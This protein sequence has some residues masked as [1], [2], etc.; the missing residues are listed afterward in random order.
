MSDLTRHPSLLTYPAPELPLRGTPSSLWERLNLVTQFTIVATVVIG[1]IMAVLGSWISSRIENSVIRYTASSAAL[2]MDRFV[3]PYLQDLAHRD[4]LSAQ[5]KAALSELLKTKA[6]NRHVIKIKIWRPD[7]TI[8]FSNIEKLIGTKPP[9]SDSLAKALTGV[10]APEFDRLS[11]VENSAE[12]VLQKPLLEIYAPVRETNGDRIIAVAE[13]YQ[14]AEDLADELFW[15]RLEGILMVGGFSLLMLGALIGIVG[16]GSQTIVTQQHALNQRI[17]E[18][19]NSLTQN[20]ELRSRLADANRRASESNERFLRRVSAELHDGPVQLIGLSLLRLDEI[21][22]LSKAPD[23]D[24]ACD[25]LEIIRSALKDA[26]TEIRALSRGLTLP[27]LDNLSL[28]ETL[29]FAITNHER[30]TGSTVGVSFHEAVPDVP[31]SIKI[32][33]YRFVQEGLNNAFRHAN[34]EGQ[35]VSVDWDGQ[36][37]KITVTDNGP[38]IPE[39]IEVTQKNGIGLAGLRDRIE[40][41]GGAIQIRAADGEGTQLQATFSIKDQTGL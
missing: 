21:R 12:R 40:S 36:L 34:G 15:V 14:I 17:D 24:R 27:E 37:L 25:T 16:R 13:F 10:V 18:L 8:V 32:C 30:R 9:I 38:G 20:M 26:L 23:D 19:S 31:P 3:E 39:I 35:R 1:I 6:F 41:L 28:T 7:G 29:D 22:S 4:D 11:D 33:A 5:S 2:Y